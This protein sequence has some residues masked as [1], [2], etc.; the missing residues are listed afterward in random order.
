MIRFEVA[1]ATDLRCGKS[2]GSLMVM[3]QELAA[4]RFAS[5]TASARLGILRAL[6]GA[7]EGLTAGEIGKAT[8]VP[9]S[10]LSGHLAQLLKARMVIRRKAVRALLYAAVPGALGELRG[11]LEALEKSEGSEPGFRLVPVA[12][13]SPE[14]LGLRAALAKNNL[15]TDDFG[16]EGQRYFALVDQGGT[17][18]GFGGLE[19]AGAD[20]LLRSLIIYPPMRGHGAGRALVRLLERQ[21]RAEGAERL[22]LLTQDA[23]KFFARLRYKTVARDKAPK[24]ITRT[25]QFAKLCPASAKLMVRGMN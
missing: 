1:A 15:P 12:F 18:F 23:E 24:A 7:G 20:Q 11:F 3:D 21:A 22:W 9:A 5:L 25:K 8:G 19:G 17:E 14:A 6:I 4:L 16:A 10:T 13:G 2:S